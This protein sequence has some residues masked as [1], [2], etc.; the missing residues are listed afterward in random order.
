[1][2]VVQAF[3]Q[4]RASERQFVHET[5]QHF[6]RLMT[7]ARLASNLNFL[8]TFLT[9]LGTILLLWW[10]GQLVIRGVLTPGR[11]V[12]FYSYVAYLYGPRDDAYRELMEAVE[13]AYP[14][15]DE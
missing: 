4:E 10:G 13:I 3:T 12:Q 11:L 9:G 2:Q 14:K 7:R 1:M 8:T 5:H 6:N 15:E